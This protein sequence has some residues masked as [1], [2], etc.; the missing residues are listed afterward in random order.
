[1][2]SSDRGMGHLFFK[3]K[4]LLI[5]VFSFLTRKEKWETCGVRGRAGANKKVCAAYKNGTD[6][7]L[8]G[9]QLFLNA[10]IVR[11]ENIRDNGIGFNR[12]LF[13]MLFYSFCFY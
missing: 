8:P 6:R 1:M 10:V 12:S 13:A 3:C 2:Y 7:K 5:S 11:Y 4:S 9:R